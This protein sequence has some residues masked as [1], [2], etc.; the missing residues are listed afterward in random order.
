LFGGSD[1]P[2]PRT[3]EIVSEQPGLNKL[4]EDELDELELLDDDE[5]DDDELD[6]RQGSEME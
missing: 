6:G 1:E 4:L 2:T 3:G 5:L